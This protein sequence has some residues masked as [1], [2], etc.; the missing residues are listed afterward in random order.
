[1]NMMRVV[2]ITEPGSADVLRVAQRCIPSPGEHEVLIKVNAA[3]INRP[4]VFQRKGLYPPPP[5]ASEIPGLEVAGEIVALGRA[6][7]QW[8]CGDRVCA[9]LTG[10]G[11]A[12]YVIAPAVQCLPVPEGLSMREAAALPETCFTVWANVFMTAQLKENE[13]FLVHGGAGG[14]GTMAI[15]FAKTAGARIFATASSNEKCH[16]C[17]QLGAEYAVNYQT[18]DFVEVLKSRTDGRGVDVILDMMGGDY[19]QKN[20]DLAATNGRIV[21]IAFLGGAKATVNFMPLMLKR[22]MLTGST[23]RVQSTEFKARIA[24]ALQQQIWPFIAMGRVRPLIFAS[25]P[26]EAAAAA[27]RLME[28]NQHIG[29]IVLDVSE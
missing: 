12:Q 25:F 28:S 6:V 16:A 21:M 24:N 4:D 15:Q 11:Y 10:G 7:T 18:E 29:K 5:G 13:I 17:K 19:L 27:H 22:L 1:M 26:L 20:I 3:G 8:H 23:L 14:I 2:E 9:L